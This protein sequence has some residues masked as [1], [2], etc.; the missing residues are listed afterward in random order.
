MLTYADVCNTCNRVPYEAFLY[1]IDQENL[2]EISSA[3]VAES[4]F[5][6]YKGDFD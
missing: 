4:P 3:L 1:Y 6:S 5:S 2:I